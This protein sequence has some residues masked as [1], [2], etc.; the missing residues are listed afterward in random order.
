M[1]GT[2]PWPGE[3]VTLLPP[4]HHPSLAEDEEGWEY[5]VF[6]S[7]FHLNPQPQSQFRRR[8]WHRRLAP[9]KVKGI[10]S[11]FLLEGSLVKP[12]WARCLFPAT[13]P[14]EPGPPGAPGRRRRPVWPDALTTAGGGTWAPEPH[15]QALDGEKGDLG[16]GWGRQERHL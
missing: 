6:G 15:P 3:R 9:N 10:A 2:H 16:L 4:Q 8:R 11:I 7:K 1:D 14:P 12:Q 5:G 13:P